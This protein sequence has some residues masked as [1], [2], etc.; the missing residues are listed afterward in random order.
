MNAARNPRPGRGQVGAP[1]EA[2]EIVMRTI[3]GAGMDCEGIQLRRAGGRDVLRILIDTDAGVTLDEV[4]DVAS[5]LS[6]ALDASGAM[7]ER[8][9]LLDVGSPG[10]DRPLTL[11]RHW[12]R[13]TG[14]LV[15]ITSTA[16]EVITGR[17]ADAQGG[18]RDAPP[19]A[20]TIER[21]GLRQRLTGDDI[22]RAVVQV[23]FTDTQLQED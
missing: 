1:A 11:L 4:A 18:A 23:E 10:V 9:Y 14:R 17:I 12:T 15:R 3:A 13:N 2:A 19:A 16:G 20:V 8:A 21:E 5:A 7:G 6:A 22:A